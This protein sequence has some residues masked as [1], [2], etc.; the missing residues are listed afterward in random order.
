MTEQ[1]LSQIADNQHL[2]EAYQRFADANG[3]YSFPEDVH[4]LSDI[5][6]ELFQFQRHDDFFIVLHKE[7]YNH[8]LHT[9]SFFELVYMAKGTAEEYVDGQKVCL[10]EG[11]LC[12]HKPGT[13]HLISKFRDEESVLI[14]ILMDPDA[15]L[16]YYFAPFIR[17]SGF[18]YFFSRFV[19][20]AS[21]ESSYLLFRDTSPQTDALIEMITATYLQNDASSRIICNGLFLALFGE[22]MRNENNNSHSAQIM[23]YIAEH[24]HD[25]TLQGMAKQFGYHEK[26][27]SHILRK[28]TGRSFQQLVT[29]VRLSRITA[30]LTYTDLSIE[31]IAMEV[32]YKNVSSLYIRFAKYFGT[33]PNEYRRANRF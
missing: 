9:H 17:D 6:K 8:S 10:Q 16:T 32:G 5:S 3:V 15:F 27:V 28:E 12:I 25:I 1:T 23:N 29:E 4:V 2:A 21:R 7:I 30:L 22:V 31:N 11:D 14:N 26:Y 20:P 19:T 18:N 33:T 13:E 24:L